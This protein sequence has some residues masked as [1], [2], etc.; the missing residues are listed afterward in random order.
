[1]RQTLYWQAVQLLQWQLSF[2]SGNTKPTYCVRVA[3][4]KMNHYEHALHFVLWGKWDDLFTL[5]LRSNDDILRKRIEQFLHAYYY[6]INHH[7]II[8][9]H[10]Q[11]IEYIDHAMK[12]NDH[13][14]LNV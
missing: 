13:H 14:S 8:E 6:S 11:L 2:L 4:S 7:E 3:Q 10:D 9:R 5:M 1:M 12:I